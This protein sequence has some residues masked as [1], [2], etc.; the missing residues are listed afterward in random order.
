MGRYF[1]NISDEE[2]NSDAIGTECADVAEVRSEA[3]ETMQELLKGR[4]LQNNDR[5][6]MA[7]NVTDEA[8]KTVMIV[9]N[10]AFV[11]VVA[12]SSLTYQTDL[13]L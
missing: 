5:T 1:F 6:Y 8:G 12:G 4:L 9:G 2:Q 7:I 10:T 3:V 13:L 11:Q